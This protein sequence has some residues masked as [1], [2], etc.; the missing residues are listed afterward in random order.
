MR[1][2]KSFCFPSTFQEGSTVEKQSQ[3]DIWGSVKKMFKDANDKAKAKVVENIS[4]A[5]K[6]TAEDKAAKEDKA[7]KEDE[8]AKEDNEESPSAEQEGLA[9]VAGGVAGMLAGSMP[10]V[11]PISAGIQIAQALE[12]TAERNAKKLADDIKASDEDRESALRAAD[13]LIESMSTMTGPAL[14]AKQKE[15]ASLLG[16]VAAPSGFGKSNMTGWKRRHAELES[17]STDFGTTTMNTLKPYFSDRAL[18]AGKCL[19]LAF[20]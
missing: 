15:V 6:K 5:N 12:A 20:H 11:D 2:T 1:L 7:V 14:T 19:V 8:A 18:V 10:A 13:E 17:V 4:K 16:A 3:E 9:A